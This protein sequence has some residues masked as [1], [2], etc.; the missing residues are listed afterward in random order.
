MAAQLGAPVALVSAFTGE[1][2]ERVFQYILGTAAG[3]FKPKPPLLEL[4]I[5]QDIPKCRT[6]AASVGEK[7]RYHAPAPPLWT[8]RLDRVFLHPLA[9]PLIFL[10][11]VV[12]VFQ[13]IFAGARPIMDGLQMIDSNH[14]RLARLAASRGAAEIAADRWQ[15]GT[16]SARWWCSCRRSCCCSCSSAFWKIPATW[17]APR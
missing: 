10:L 11:V 3:R 8:R 12:A 14:R 13:T 17:P 6:W 2:V 15:F 9:G 5:L 4:P 16:A 1:G 7:A